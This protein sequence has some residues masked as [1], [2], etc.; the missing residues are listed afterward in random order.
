MHARCHRSF[1]LAG[2][3]CGAP[4]CSR[5]IKEKLD[6]APESECSLSRLPFPSGYGRRNTVYAALFAPCSLRGSSVYATHIS[7]QRRSTGPERLVACPSRHICLCPSLLEA[8]TR[9]TTLLWL[10]RLFAV[11]R[12][13]NPL[14]SSNWSM[15]HQ[16]AD[17]TLRW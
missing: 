11:H 16:C 14:L 8:Q 9:T 2:L 1:I 6:E 17:G 4:C 12:R 5:E 3:C 13:P 10:H 15:L 7:R